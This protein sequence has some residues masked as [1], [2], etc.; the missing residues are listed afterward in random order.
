MNSSL[1]KTSALGIFFGVGFLCGFLVGFGYAS[2]NIKIE[3]QVIG[4]TKDVAAPAS[5]DNGMVVSVLVPNETKE[6]DGVSSVD[7]DLV[8]DDHWMDS[9]ENGLFITG[10]VINES[11]HSFTG[12][13]IAFDLTDSNG[14]PYT[15]VTDTAKE[16]MAPSDTW[17]FTIYIPYS[18]MDKF[19]SYRLQSIMGVTDR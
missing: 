4:Q 7:I 11:D 12:V 8:L 14:E 16:R 2:F 18:D 3:T 1:K 15:T 17:G 10:A 6:P 9:D 5:P 13:R 19:S